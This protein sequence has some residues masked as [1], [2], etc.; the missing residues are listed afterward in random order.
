ME[1]NT[2]DPTISSVPRSWD[3]SGRACV[4]GPAAAGADAF[5]AMELVIIDVAQKASPVAWRPGLGAIG[6]PIKGP[7]G[8]EEKRKGDTRSM[9]PGNGSAAGPARGRV[10]N[11]PDR[12]KGA[13]PPRLH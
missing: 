6:P 1:K 5:E 11:S 9:S 12:V 10:P 7:F 3:W 13:V 4:C 2:V 8:P